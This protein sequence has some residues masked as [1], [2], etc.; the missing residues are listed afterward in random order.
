[1][2][3]GGPYRF[4][5]HPRYLGMVVFE[6]AAPV[7][8]ASWGAMLISCLNVLLIILRT[9]LED[10]ALQA[11]LPGYAEYARRVRYRLLPGIW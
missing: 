7:L 5:R 10:H 11:K 1:M 8:L 9:V 2:A 3:V 6:L 4:V